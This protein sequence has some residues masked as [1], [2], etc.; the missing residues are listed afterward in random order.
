MWWS[1]A[2]RGLTPP[3]I[4]VRVELTSPGGLPWNWGPED[5][6]DRVVGTALG[7]CLVVTQRRHV[8]D[9]DLT[10]SGDAAHEWMRIAQAF[11]GLPALGPK[12]GS[13]RKISR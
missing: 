13:F 6:K 5:A 12:P 9:T 11:A 4:P 2:N 7:F 10:T 3:D 1:Y 8:E